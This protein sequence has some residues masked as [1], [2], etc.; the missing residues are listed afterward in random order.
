VRARD[1]GDAIRIS[2]VPS[3]LRDGLMKAINEWAEYHCTHVM[4]EGETLHALC[5]V[6][7][8]R[9][10]FSTLAPVY[11]DLA[12]SVAKLDAGFDKLL[13]ACRASLL[14][15]YLRTRDVEEVKA[16]SETLGAIIAS[17]KWPGWQLDF[18]LEIERRCQTPTPAA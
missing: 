7:E 17:G 10:I 2:D 9:R 4:R 1:I 6:V 16:I 3:Y 13:V 12:D 18:D 15:E 5:G 11:P 14:K 8:L